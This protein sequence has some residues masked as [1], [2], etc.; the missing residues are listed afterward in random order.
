MPHLPGYIPPL[1]MDASWTEEPSSEVQVDDLFSL[2]E[3]TSIIPPPAIGS[4]GSVRD[5]KERKIRGTGGHDGRKRGG[6][7]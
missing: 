7:I 3:N 2:P 5:D 4:S 6:E 1:T